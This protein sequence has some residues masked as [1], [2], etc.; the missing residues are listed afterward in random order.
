MFKPNEFAE[1]L[2][3]T[4]RTLQRWDKEGI[5][6]AN[7]TPTNRRYYTYSQYIDY[8]KKNLLEQKSSSSTKKTIGYA[9]VSNHTNMRNL[10]SQVE[11]IK[12]Y[13]NENRLKID[14]ISQDF[15]SGL[16]YKREGWNRLLDLCI[17]NEVDTILITRKDRFVRFGYEWFESFLSR[18]N[19]KIIVVGEKNTFKDE[20]IEDL[21]SILDLFS[22]EVEELKKYSKS[23]KINKTLK[24]ILS[25]KK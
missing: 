6:K 9:R 23:I 4:V 25:L 21:I 7:R 16:N 24:H 20:I 12:K 17:S 18:F 14:T 22:K 10:S 5:L 2:N 8:K 11:S 3:V 13:A 19:V 1:L 15:G